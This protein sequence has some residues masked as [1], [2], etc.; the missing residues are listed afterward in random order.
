M[1]SR[2]VLTLFI[3]VLSYSPTSDPGSD[4][5]RQSCYLSLSGLSYSDSD[6]GVF[7]PT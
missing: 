4:P 7:T 3:P 1:F 5:G 6:S 2:P